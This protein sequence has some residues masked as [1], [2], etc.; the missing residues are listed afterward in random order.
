MKFCA[1]RVPAPAV[2][3]IAVRPEPARVRHWPFLVR[4]L[5]ALRNQIVDPLCEPR[6]IKLGQ[7]LSVPAVR[8]KLGLQNP[9]QFGGRDG[10]STGVQLRVRCT[11]VSCRGCCRAEAARPVPRTD[12]SGCQQGLATAQ[13]AA[14][15]A[16]DLYLRSRPLRPP[17]AQACL[18]LLPM[19]DVFER[20]AMRGFEVSADGVG[21]GHKADLHNVGGN[22]KKLCRLVT[23]AQMEGGKS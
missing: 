23:T 15:D 18:P 21:N 12:L 4:P 6:V 5:A 7:N 17:N 10:P 14:L 8:L 13:H 22:A 3:A 19:R 2:A 11:T 20:R 1:A 9:N 16:A